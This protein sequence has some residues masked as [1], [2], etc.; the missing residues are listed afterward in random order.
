MIQMDTLDKLDGDKEEFVSKDHEAY[1][2]RYG[3]DT[4]EEE[5]EAILEDASQE[6]VEVLDI[7]NVSSSIISSMES[8]MAL[9]DQDRI[10]PLTLLHNQVMNTGFNI[11]P[12]LE[13]ARAG[14]FIPEL[15]QTVG[16]AERLTS[17]LLRWAGDAIKASYKIL[18]YSLKRGAIF[19]SRTKKDVIGLEDRLTRLDGLM[20]SRKR[21]D[22]RIFFSK[23]YLEM[24][25]DEYD[26]NTQPAGAVSSFVS[27]I[28]SIMD[29][30]I[31]TVKKISVKAEGHLNGS[32]TKIDIDEYEK[33]IKDLVDGLEDKF[34]DKDQLIGNLYVKVNK[35]SK[36]SKLVTLEVGRPS[37]STAVSRYRPMDALTNSE[38]ESQRTSLRG[39]AIKKMYAMLDNSG[40][41]MKEISKFSKLVSSKKFT[42]KGDGDNK[43]NK[44][45]AAL[46][47]FL[48]EN[49]KELMEGIFT[50]SG[51]AYERVDVVVKLLEDSVSVD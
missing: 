13:N 40:E 14:D 6:S 2:R 28:Y 4:V 51:I 5:M 9:D 35:G 50:L 32:D 39:G 16:D 49:V 18:V 26:I 1:E 15:N 41:T 33:I 27:V 21:E 25:A 46:S 30:Y 45:L 38:V 31:S 42:E 47:K 7:L 23:K 44:D 3:R 29:E 43:E 10:L 17:T 12:S 34:K 36:L 22:N 19:L 37:P 8:V 48:N 11:G 20:K 24:L